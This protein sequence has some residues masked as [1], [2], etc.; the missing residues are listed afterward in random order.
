M[1]VTYHSLPASII[2]CGAMLCGAMQT[3][4]TNCY[5]D[6]HLIYSALNIMQTNAD[7]TLYPSRLL[8]GCQLR[9][10]W[11]LLA[12]NNRQESLANAKVSARRHGACMK[13]PSEEIYGKSTQGTLKSTFSGL[14][15]CLWQY[16]FRLVFVASQIC[17]I[18]PEFSENSNLSQFK[19]INCGANRK[20]ICNFLLVINSNFGCV[21]PLLFNAP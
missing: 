2:Q 11:S 10:P 9:E 18:L 7:Y 19:V 5:S 17:E 1:R 21:T 20:R 12:A 16:R 13:A 4:M 8:D 6:D 15:R 14:Q 3:I